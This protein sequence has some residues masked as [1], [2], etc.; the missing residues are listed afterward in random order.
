V[1]DRPLPALEAAYPQTGFL[2]LDS[3]DSEGEVF[4]IGAADL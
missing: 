4:W 3:E 1:R 2:W